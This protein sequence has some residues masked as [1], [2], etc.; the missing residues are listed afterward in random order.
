[1]EYAP[2]AKPPVDQMLVLPNLRDYAETRRDW[3]WDAVRNELDGMPD[4]ALNKAHECLDRHVKGDRRDKP[5]DPGGSRGLR[6]SD[7]ERL[8]D[9]IARRLLAVGRNP[10]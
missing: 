9:G 4:G 6:K 8:H 10:A 2:I 7:P 1:M 3:S 5:A